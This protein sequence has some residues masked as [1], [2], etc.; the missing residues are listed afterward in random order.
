MEIPEKNKVP[1]DLIARFLNGEADTDDIIDLEQWKAASGENART[2]EEYRRI[3]EKT[4]Q[5]SLFADI[6]IE[7]EWNIFLDN[8]AAQ[9]TM[10]KKESKA[11]E[12]PL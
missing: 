1:I 6:D 5:L 11:K 3:W 12:N 10:H 2:F 7:E 4:G 8:T 9:P